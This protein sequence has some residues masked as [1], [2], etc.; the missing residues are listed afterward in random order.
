MKNILKEI[1]TAKDI[2][3]TE[4]AEMCSVSRQT[5]HSIEVNKY[6]PSVEL[7][8][9]ISKILKKKVEDIFIL[10]ETE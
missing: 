8:I 9:K 1:R 3:Q 5:I 2:N 10:E 7:A 6:I 4:L